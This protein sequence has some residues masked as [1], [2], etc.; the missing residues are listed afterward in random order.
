MARVSGM[1][2]AINGLRVD[3]ADRNRETIDLWTRAGFRHE[4]APQPAVAGGKQGS[5]TEREQNPARSYGRYRILA[6]VGRGGSGVVY[7]A[8]DPTIGRTVALKV[9]REPPGVAPGEREAFRARLQA[10]AELAG[11]LQHPHI[12]TL[13]DVGED[14]V[15]MEFLEGRPLSSLIGHG[16]ALEPATTLRLG[17]QL[18]LALDFAHARGIV[19]RAVRPANVM[20]LPS[21]D[22]K[23]MDF[24]VPRARLRGQLAVARETIP[25][26]Y[27]A[28]ERLAGQRADARSDVYSLGA[29]V[30]EMLTGEAPRASSAM[31]TPSEVAPGADPLLEVVV[32]KALRPDPG[33]RYASA[34]DFISAL[35]SNGDDDPLRSLVAPSD[36]AA[37]APPSER[38]QDD[39]AR[40]ERSRRRH[41]LGIGAVA[42]VAAA[43]ALFAVV[44]GWLPV[45][46]WRK[47]S[48]EQRATGASQAAPPWLPTPAEGSAGR[49]EASGSPVTGTVGTLLV[50]STP[51]EARVFIDGIEK[52][53]TPLVTQLP[54]GRALVRVEKG[55]YQAASRL[56]WVVHG[57]SV[58][59]SLPLYT[60]SEFRSV[61]VL[62]LPHGGRLA[63]DGDLVGRTNALDVQLAPGFH[64]LEIRRPGFQPWVEEVEVGPDTERV[65][66]TLVKQPRKTH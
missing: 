57:R 21:G 39:E 33:E 15:V 66:A 12:M 2:I 29:V 53:T 59:L 49:L 61:D 36:A 18:A 37:T 43:A 4:G 27:E 47:P 5:V 60:E 42:A 34:G 16:R 51:A 55:G 38:L 28:P 41:G 63:I 20:V 50:S 9:L 44:S 58:G 31:A 52:G 24:G 45:S 25:D 14:Y 62:S 22:L 64:V 3:R 56:A 48:P 1:P 11:A 32:R 6:E 26:A 35:E 30:H 13:Y 7:K 23:V 10:E 8:E 40:H 46:R 17:R 65:I 54:P 19:H